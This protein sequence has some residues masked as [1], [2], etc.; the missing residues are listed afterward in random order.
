VN[1]VKDAIQGGI[2]NVVGNIKGALGL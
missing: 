1:Q 2:Q